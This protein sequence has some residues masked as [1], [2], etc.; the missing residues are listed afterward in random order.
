MREPA[1]HQID[2]G[3]LPVDGP[4]EDLC[5]RP[6]S[7]QVA[8]EFPSLRP[9]RNCCWQRAIA[10]QGGIRKRPQPRKES[11]SRLKT[12]HS[13]A[14]DDNRAYVRSY[15]LWADLNRGSLALAVGVAAGVVGSVMFASRNGSGSRRRAES[16]CHA[17]PSKRFMRSEDLG[18]QLAS[19]SKTSGV[20][21]SSYLNSFVSGSYTD[22]PE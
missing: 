19:L 22:S 5:S 12:E 11:S 6:R 21:A 8:R 9:Q 16:G 4:L 1:A 20:L 10:G 14:C 17:E 18:A 7:T 2:S 3:T 15:Q 13:R